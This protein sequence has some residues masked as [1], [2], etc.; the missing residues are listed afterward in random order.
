MSAEPRTKTCRICGEAKR[1]SAFDRQDAGFTRLRS[2]CKQCMVALNTAR[3][4]RKKAPLYDRIVQVLTDHGP[5]T[6]NEIASA[7]AM[8]VQKISPMM[9]V[10]RQAGRVAGEPHPKNPQITLWRTPKQ[11]AP[12]P[13]IPPPKEAAPKPDPPPPLTAAS[14][15]GIDEDDLQWMAH[16]RARHAQRTQRGNCQDMAAA[17]LNRRG[18]QRV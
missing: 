10:L 3:Q 13:Q 9:G 14:E 1:L 17:V 6:G 11:P 12:P 16:Y 8:S 18:E 7:M 5:L 4:A 15:A 2:E